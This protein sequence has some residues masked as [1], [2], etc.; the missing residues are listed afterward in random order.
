VSDCFGEGP[1]WLV[2]NSLAY[3][4]YCTTKGSFG[5]NRGQE[6][7]KLFLKEEDE[8]SPMALYEAGLMS[9]HKALRLEKGVTIV[10][11]AKEYKTSP[12]VINKFENKGIIRFIPWVKLAP[13]YGSLEDVTPV[14][15]DHFNE[16]VELELKKYFDEIIEGG[17]ETEEASER[18]LSIVKSITNKRRKHTG[19]TN[20]LAEIRELV[21]NQ[22][23]I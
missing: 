18:I 2:I 19:R 1:V 4:Q 15:G 3:D 23:L 21:E 6:K 12:E 13:F 9:Y 7:K 10:G 8:C 11:L 22:K 5:N 14:Y 16:E 17:A 20:T